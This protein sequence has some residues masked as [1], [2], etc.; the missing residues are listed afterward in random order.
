[1][2]HVIRTSFIKLAALLAA[3]LVYG[4]ID[5]APIPASAA[6]GPAAKESV[7]KTLIVGVSWSNFQ[8]ERWKRDESA[9]K[10]VLAKY[11]ADYIS[12]DAEA[13]NDKQM[14]DIDALVARGAKAIIV[15]AWDADAILPAIEKANA[16]GVSIIAYDRMIQS[17][18]VFYIT[19]DN[20]EVGRIQAREIL[21]RKAQG[22][23]AFIKGAETDPNSV[24][25]YKGQME[26]LDSAIK[27]GEIKSVG[28]Q[29]TEGW[30][31]DNARKNMLEMLLKNGNRID[32]VVASN[33]G[34]AGGAIDALRSIGLQ[35]I[36]V[37]GQDCDI[38]ALN[39]IARGQQS[40]SV[41][42]DPRKLG[43][44]AAW[45]ASQL[46]SGKKLDEIVGTIQWSGGS[47][48]IPL[49]ALLLRP[50]PITTRNLE[51]VLASRWISKEQL[52]A[53]VDVAT[54]PGVCK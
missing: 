15:L 36:P 43:D 51:L 52:C 31:P 1:M 48:Q 5:A 30:K 21:K 20:V 37:S 42:K 40:V 44:A 14:R 54:G 39:R 35:D 41:F 33:D 7:T 34:T 24:M 45:V 13:S 3:T 53:G 27:R 2:H 32:A 19:F 29:F 8:E 18:D 25:L 23:Y 10:Q 38:A 50:V 47:K 49:T 9:I 4:T 28:N 26:V 46:A 6:K 12:A 17:K 16:Q 22:N 11:G